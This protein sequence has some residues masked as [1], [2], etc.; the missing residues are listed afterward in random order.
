MKL[1]IA[2]K[3]GKNYEH[4]RI[5]AEATTPDGATAKLLGTDNNN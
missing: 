2:S 4:T 5:L 3:M 1:T